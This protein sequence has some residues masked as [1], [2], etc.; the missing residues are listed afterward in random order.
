[1]IVGDTSNLQI[2]IYSKLNVA[3]N[4][5]GLETSSFKLARDSM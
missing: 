5:T 2:Y 3:R 4:V 1:M